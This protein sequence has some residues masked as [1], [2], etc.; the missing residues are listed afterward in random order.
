ML[1]EALGYLLLDTG[2]MYRAVTL[3][4]LRDGIAVYDEAAIVALSHRIDIVIEPPETGPD[5]GRLYTVKLDGDDVTWDLRTADVDAHVS[6]V[7]AYAGVREELVRRQRK[8]AATGHVVMVGRDIGTVVVPDA[9]LKLY[10]TASP[11]ERARRRWLERQKRG[12]KETYE[13]ILADV[14]RR[15]GIDSNRAHSP[16]K[17]ADDAIV[18]DTTEKSPELVVERILGLCYAIRD[19]EAT[20]T[21]IGP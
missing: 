18:I 20:R 21:E 12:S 13:T 10:V 9:P 17:A 14:K 7:S 19:P 11:E 15:D 3:A 6:R 4:A 16:L 8:M 1:A 5:D 2:S